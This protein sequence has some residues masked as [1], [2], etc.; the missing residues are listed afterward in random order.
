MARKCTPTRVRARPSPVTEGKR[1]TRCLESPWSPC[2]SEATAQADADATTVKLD[3]EADDNE[4]D[5][6]ERGVGARG[7]A[8]GNGAFKCEKCSRSFKGSTLLRSPTCC[9]V[10][11]SSLPTMKGLY[12]WPSGSK[13][14][15]SRR[16]AQSPTSTRCKMSASRRLTSVATYL[17]CASASKRPHGQHPL[18]H[19]SP[20][21]THVA[22]LM[23]GHWTAPLDLTRG[24]K[25][26]SAFHC[27]TRKRVGSERRSVRVSPSSSGDS[28][29]M[30]A[31]AR[32]ARGREGAGV[33]FRAGGRD[34]A[35]VARPP[36]STHPE[37]A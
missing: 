2:M 19:V 30:V 3:D 16:T 20:P 37:V 36:S 6:E 12:P 10:A 11:L 35:R 8:T 29:H 27:A 13:V 17:K 1:A 33:G 14:R 23:Q 28:L 5:E 18:S 4:E 7:D 21:P 26:H 15:S 32:G 31:G 34:G 24:E 9:P 25:S 22:A